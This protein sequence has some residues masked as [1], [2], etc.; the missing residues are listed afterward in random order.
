[1]TLE[2]A[3]IWARRMKRDVVALWVAA[4]DPRTSFAVT[5]STDGSAADVDPATGSAALLASDR[6]RAA[7]ALLAGVVPADRLRLATDPSPRGRAATVSLA[8]GGERPTR[9][10]R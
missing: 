10:S 6:A 7:A 3:K 4:R 2:Q 5:A 8:F 1:M 9:S